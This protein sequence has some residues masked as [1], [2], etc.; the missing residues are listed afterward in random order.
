MGSAM[1]HL[2]EHIA[3][4]RNPEAGIEAAGTYQL[5]YRAWLTTALG[6]IDTGQKTLMLPGGYLIWSSAWPTAELNKRTNDALTPF[7]LNE[8]QFAK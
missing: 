1:V 4:L 5:E 8:E 7:L 3:D 6:A 2:G